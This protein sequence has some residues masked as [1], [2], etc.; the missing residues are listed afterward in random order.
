[1]RDQLRDFEA[2]LPRTI[3]KVD[4]EHADRREPAESDAALVGVDP[5]AS[6]STSTSG[7]R[8]AGP[9]VNAPNA[10][11][12]PS[13]WARLDPAPAPDDAPLAMKPL[14]DVKRAIDAYLER[15]LN[16]ARTKRDTVRNEGD[17]DE[18]DARPKPRR[19]GSQTRSPETYEPVEKFLWNQ[20]ST[21]ENFLRRQA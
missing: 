11:A 8:S 2:R 1:M 5:T 16:P 14:R 21:D 7:E 12:H 9:A 20:N 17:R 19:P 6:A 10:N 4:E 3:E 18:E 15:N 13:A